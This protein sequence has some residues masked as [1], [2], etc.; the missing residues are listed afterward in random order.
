ML[1]L[2]IIIHTYLE[3]KAS[4]GAC[5]SKMD[6]L[7]FRACFCVNYVNYARECQIERRCHLWCVHIGLLYDDYNDCGYLCGRVPIGRFSALTINRVGGGTR[8]LESGS[9]SV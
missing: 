6:L 8:E 5:S 1:S 7:L 2:Y 3:F 9:K 4:E